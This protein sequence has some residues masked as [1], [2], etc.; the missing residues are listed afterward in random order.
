MPFRHLRAPITAIAIMGGM[1]GFAGPAVAA[2]PD[3]NGV[4]A[5]AHTDG[6]VYYGS[7]SPWASCYEHGQDLVASGVTTRFTC[8]ASDFPGYY[9]LFRWT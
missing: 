6:Y 9:D 7:Y 1:L 4:S 2:V 8:V 3:A 5:P